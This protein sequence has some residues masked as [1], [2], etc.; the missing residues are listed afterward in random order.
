MKALLILLLCFAAAPGASGP[1]FQDRK[2]YDLV[3]QIQLEKDPSRRL[4]LL[5]RWARSYPDSA[6]RQERWNQMIIAN[7]TLGHPRKMRDLARHMAADNP[8]GFG[9]YWLAT[10][11]INLQ[12]SSTQALEEGQRAADAILKNAAENFSAANCPSSV[13]P[14]AWEKERNRQVL[15]AH[16]TLGWVALQRKQYPEAVVELKQVVSESPDDDAEA[17][18]WLG[19]ALLAQQKPELQSRALFCFALSLSVT[20]KGAL[21]P[22]ARRLV[23]PYFESTY[24]ALNGS[25]QGMGDFVRRASTV[26]KPE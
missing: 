19:S 6:F 25:N 14:A 26:F 8:A 4:A 23:A 16:R 10:L 20:G 5:D 17:L 13:S 1:Q 21:L 7:R 24:T 2:E 22:E 9:N 11:T 12:D 3:G 18:F 15:I